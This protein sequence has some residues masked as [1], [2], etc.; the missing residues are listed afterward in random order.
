[1]ANRLLLDAFLETLWPTRCAC[2]D[3]PG[4]VLCERCEATLEYLDHWKACPRC[5]APW[6]VVQCDRCGSQEREGG[7][8]L[9]FCISALRHR[10]RAALL[11]RT[12]KD[13]G[14]QRLASALAGLV[15]NAIPPSWCT[16]ADAVTFVPATAAARRRRGFDHM[17]L[18]AEELSNL[19]GLPA[20]AS[21]MPPRALDQRAL[22]RA[23][24][25]SNMAGRFSVVHPINPR[26]VIL[27]DDVM[28][29]GATLTE[30]KRALEEHKFDVRLASVTRV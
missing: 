6:G 19:L 1:M 28:T 20:L 13:K 7:R 11:V 29:T 5:G 17:E 12:Y 2:C 27:V 22:G 8:E 21:L 10:G 23:G 15:S 3:S 4:S 16:W 9:P 30:A 24:R 26:R 25:I 14:E 18:F